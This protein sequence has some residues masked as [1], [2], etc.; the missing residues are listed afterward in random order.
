MASPRLRH[1]VEIWRGTEAD[2]GTGGSRTEWTRI[3]RPWA[4]VRGLP[5]RESSLEHVLQGISVYRVMIRHRDDILTADQLRHGAITMNIK[6]AV[7][8]DGRREWLVITADTQAVVA[9]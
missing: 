4:D 2:T 7:D 1:R 3:A 8:P 6:S 5:G 9:Q